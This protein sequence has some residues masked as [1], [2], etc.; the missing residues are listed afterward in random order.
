[1]WQK[2]SHNSNF[3]GITIAAS[4]QMCRHQ[5]WY[6]TARAWQLAYYFESSQMAQLYATSVDSDEDLTTRFSVV[7]AI[8][9]W[10]TWNLG[11]RNINHLLDAASG[12]FDAYC[13]EHMSLFEHVVMLIKHSFHFVLHLVFLQNFSYHIVIPKLLLYM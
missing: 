3:I 1:M 11:K 6:K 13:Y 5:H 4:Y 2:Y 12:I 9:S 8:V 10:N 7:V